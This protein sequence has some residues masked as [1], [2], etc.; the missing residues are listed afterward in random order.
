MKTNNHIISKTFKKLS[1]KFTTRITVL[2]IILGTFQSQAQLSHYLQ[3]FNESQTFYDIKAGMTI[4]LDS[5]KANQDSATFYA[6]GGEYDTYRRFENY[7]EMRLYPHGEFTKAI[8]AE[9]S[10]NYVSS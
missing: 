9:T 10:K 8:K 4:Y 2:F 1:I 6:E 3:N 7:W 5:L